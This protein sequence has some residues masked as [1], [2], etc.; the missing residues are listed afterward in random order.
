MAIRERRIR[1]GQKAYDVI[2]RRPDGTQYSRTFRSKREAVRFESQQNVDR[3]RAEW[4]DPALGSVRFEDYAEQWLACRPG[5]RPRTVELYRSELKCHL[6]PAFGPMPLSHI[7]PQEVRAWYARLSSRR[8][9][10]AAK[11]YR[12]LAAIFNTAVADG[13]IPNSPCR[14]RGAGTEKSPE[15][16]LPTVEQAI[17]VASAIDPRY[18][19]IVLLAA[20]CGLR[21]G[22]LQGLTRADVDLERRSISVTK[23]RQEVAGEEGIV[24]SEPKSRAGVRQVRIPDSIIPAL[25]EHLETWTGPGSDGSLFGGERGGLRRA[26]FYR[27]WRVAVGG[28]GLPASVHLHDLRHVAN[29]LA[30]RVPGT[31]TKDLM[32]RMGHASPDAALRYLHAS[33]EADAAIADGIDAEI[34]RR[35]P[36]PEI[37][38]TGP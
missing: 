12:L 38:N 20:F 30:A 6:L 16:R 33:P 3:S 25:A 9:V 1:G 23:Q 15:R 2:L 26:S 14:I 8:Q 5:L 31:T 32:A 21:L 28:V 22:E 36:G 29:T 10:T 19:G 13:I 7:R 4:R 27:A 35:H 34:R 11:C 37:G 24:M 17:A 18:R